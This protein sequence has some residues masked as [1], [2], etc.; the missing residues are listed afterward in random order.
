MSAG[1][2]SMADQ[3]VGEADERCKGRCHPAGRAYIFS[4]TLG[5]GLENGL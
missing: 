5:Q 3:E 2:L 1:A 4:C